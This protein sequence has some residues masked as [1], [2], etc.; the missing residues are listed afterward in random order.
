MACRPLLRKVLGKNSIALMV[1]D[2]HKHM[3]STGLDFLNV[4]MF[5]TIFLQDADR[6]ASQ[7]VSSLK[8]GRVIS[9]T[10]EVTELRSAGTININTVLCI[11]VM[12]QKVNQLM[13]N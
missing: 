6:L 10:D 11:D 12:T 7:I 8:E 13:T 1:G 4:E 5:R 3:R 9:A 2:A